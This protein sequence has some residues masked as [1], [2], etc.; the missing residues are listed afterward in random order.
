[1]SGAHLRRVLGELDIRTQF[2]PL[3]TLRKLLV[4]VKDPVPDGRKM[5]VVYQIACKNCPA[6]CIG[7]T[8][9]LSQRFKEHKSALV[10]A[11]PHNSGAA[12][13][14]M[15]TGHDI[16]WDNVKIM[17]C[18][19]FFHQRIALETRHM[20]KQCLRL[21]HEEGVLPLVYNVLIAGDKSGGGVQATHH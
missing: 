3:R 9:S 18:M 15:N 7:Q 16:D 12:E 13:H 14:A 6:M 10:N 21:G 8:R 1:M 11:H 2:K 19:L 20:K 5:G 4:Q 17:A